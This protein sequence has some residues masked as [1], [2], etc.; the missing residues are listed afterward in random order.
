MAATKRRK[1]KA[2]ILHL[3]QRRM[4]IKRSCLVQ[5]LEKHYFPLLAEYLFLSVTSLCDQES[6]IQEL[7]QP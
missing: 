3:T 5:H 4:F 1:A 6:M 2:V 7:E